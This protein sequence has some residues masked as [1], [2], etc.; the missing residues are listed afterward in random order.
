MSGSLRSLANVEQL[1]Q[2]C[3]SFT[4]MY[5]AATAII[6]LEGE[7][8]V[9]AGWQ[10]A[11]TKFHRVHPTTALRCHESDTVL[12]S[13][14]QSGKEYNVYYCQNGLVDVAVPIRVFGIHIANLFTGQFFFE[15]PQRR[16]FRE[17][18]RE[19]GFDEALYL[20][21]IDE[22]PI[23]PEEQVRSMMRFLRELAELIGELGQANQTLL[24]QKK[25]I[26]RQASYDP[27]TDLPN[28]LLLSRRTDEE[29]ARATRLQREFAYLFVDLD[30]FKAV[31]DT[32]GH[33]IGDLLLSHVARRIQSTARHYDLVSRL[34][35][36][37]FVVM[38][39]EFDGHTNASRV[40]ADIIAAL[41]EPCLLKDREF[42]L[43]ASIGIAVFP[44][45]GSD[46]VSLLQA[47]D[48]AMYQAKHSGKGCFR[49]FS[50]ATSA[51]SCVLE[52]AASCP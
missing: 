19:M 21:A 43:S 45:D 29:I 18:A 36:D 10:N 25:T 49:Y 40:A 48:Q 15:S 32:A 46:E 52:E 33:G 6:D 47:S 22:V 1:Q 26:E 50:S 24:E 27:L 39:T 7:V 16:Q 2:L 38:L 4:E 30:G 51:D 35:G 3:T 5:G 34:G 28:R 37:E 13:K 12:A 14:L 20:H 8:L 31:N 9:A 17:Q 42:N 11:C 41:S 23:F 44:R